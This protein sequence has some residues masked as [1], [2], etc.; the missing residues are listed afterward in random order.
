[1]K[2]PSCNQEFKWTWKRYFNY[3][4]GKLPCPLC[5]TRIVLKHRWLYRLLIFFSFLIIGIPLRLVIGLV[6][7]LIAFLIVML[8]DKF[9]DNKL[10]ILRIDEKY[11]S[12]KV[13]SDAA[14]KPNVSVNNQEVITQNES[15]TE[16]TKNTT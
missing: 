2:C 11:S 4:F 12:A 6:G 8:F 5:Q 1:M 7:Y 16:N 3:P 10:G 14:N 13:E 9:L 15:P